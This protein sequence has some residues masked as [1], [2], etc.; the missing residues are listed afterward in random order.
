[1]KANGHLSSL[2]GTRSH[3]KKKHEGFAFGQKWLPGAGK[4][5]TWFDLG[6]I[7]GVP[8][9]RWHSNPFLA[10]PFSAFAPDLAPV[11]RP[12]G[13]ERGK[14]HPL[15]LAL[16]WRKLLDTDTSLTR[17]D[18]AEQ[19]GLK[20]ARIDQILRLTKLAP[21]ILEALC[22]M[23]GEQLKRD[24]SEPKLRK[25]IPLQPEE[26]RVIFSSMLRSD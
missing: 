24:F 18:L 21:E 10:W 9:G 1:M 17:R 19:E 2:R 5:R 4:E 25:L 15:M 12:K 23:P 3:P 8:H 11:P 26:Q 20:R 16:H 13:L 7:V 22:K 14:S 6:V